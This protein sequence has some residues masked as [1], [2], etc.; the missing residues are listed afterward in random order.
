MDLS[1][2][3]ECME[4]FAAAGFLAEESVAAEFL[5]SALCAAIQK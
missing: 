4:Q 5:I 2:H 1:T 3:P